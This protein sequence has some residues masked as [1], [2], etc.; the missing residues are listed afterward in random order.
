MRSLRDRRGSTGVGRVC[1]W[2]EKVEENEWN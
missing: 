2:D 1:L